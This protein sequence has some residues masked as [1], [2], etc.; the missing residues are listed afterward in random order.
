MLYILYVLTNISIIS[1]QHRIV[2][3]SW[4]TLCSIYSSLLPSY[5]SPGTP[6]NHWF[7]YCLV[8]LYYILSINSKLNAP[9]VAPHITMQQIFV[10][11]IFLKN[12]L[13]VSRPVPLQTCC[14]LA[15]VTGDSV[16]FPVFWVSGFLFLSFL[17][18]FVV[19]HSPVTLWKRVLG[20]GVVF[21]EHFLSENTFILPSL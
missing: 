19:M 21:W 6:G 20:Q 5:P 14:P 18:H 8:V 10:N 17:A 7:F 1:V 13:G 15:L 9:S 11:F 2:S 4:K 3:L 12:S 16:G